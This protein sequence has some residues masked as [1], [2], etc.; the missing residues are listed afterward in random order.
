MRTRASAG[1]FLIVLAAL[2]AGCWN[3]NLWVNY[4][5]VEGRYTVS[6]PSQPTL[7]TQDSATATGDKLTQYF[8]TSSDGKEVFITAYFDYSQSQSFTLDK[9]RDG[10]VNAVKG[11]ILSDTPITLASWPGEQVKIDAKE[12]DV[13]LIMRVKFY[14]VDHRVYI[15]QCIAPKSEDGSAVEQKANRYFDSFSLTGSK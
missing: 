10:M 5:S 4:T 11:T 1:V 3:S 14:N 8:A 2:A 12:G 15:L 13:E 7:K 6:V 9:A